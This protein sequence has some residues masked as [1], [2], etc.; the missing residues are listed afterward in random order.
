MAEWWECP[1]FDDVRVWAR[2][3]V[4]TDPMG[5]PTYSWSHVDVH[6]V[7]VN[8]VTAQSMR[9]GDTLSDLRPDGVRVLYRLAF[10]RDYDGPDLRHARVTLL[11]ETYGMDASVTDGWRT[12]L[13]V[14][15][16]P[17]HNPARP[18]RWDMLVDVG[19][20]HG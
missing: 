2:T 17:R 3:R 15:G 11:R 9:Q 13:V 4:G 20:T 8:E 7:I 5:E 19:Y 1:V 16:D 6:G 12:A 18:T 14:S 10:P